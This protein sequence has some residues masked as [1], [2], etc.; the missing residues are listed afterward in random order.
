MKNKI[1][2]SFYKTLCITCLFIASSLF[3][4]S[5]AEGDPEVELSLEI[6]ASGLE[7]VILDASMDEVAEPSVTMSAI[8][9]SAT[10]VGTSTGTLG[11]D[12]QWIGIANNTGTTPEWTASIGAT[13]GASAV[14]SDGSGKTMPFNSADSDDGTLTIVHTNTTIA[15]LNEEGT[16]G[17]TKGSTASFLSGESYV[18]ITLVTAGSTAPDGGAWSVKNIGLSQTVP[19]LQEVATYTLD[20]T[21]TIT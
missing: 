3:F 10:E 2:L 19:M 20:L 11:T 13:G 18:P 12:P 17:I 5:F 4:V 16:T 14:W 8:D 9:Y 1:L 21:L 6:E 15:A 7:V